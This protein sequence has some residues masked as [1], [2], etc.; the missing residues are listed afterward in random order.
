V[1]AYI[2]PI[3]KKDIFVRTFITNN[4]LT[5]KPNLTVYAIKTNVDSSLNTINNT[6]SN[7][8][9]ILKNKFVDNKF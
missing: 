8:Q 3:T 1:L 7:K 2:L 9:N 4:I 6:L 5:N